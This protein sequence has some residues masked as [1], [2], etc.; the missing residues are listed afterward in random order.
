MR[1]RHLSVLLATLAAGS[2]ALAADAARVTLPVFTTAE[3][4]NQSCEQGLKATRTAI[5]TLARQPLEAV[6]TATTLAMWDD[7]AIR[8]EDFASPV[9]IAQNVSP[10]KAVRDAAEACSQ[11]VAEL[12][13][14]LYQNVE[15]Y[16]R[17]RRVTD[18]TGAAA[19]LRKV[20]IEGFEDAGATLPEDKRK[21]AKEILDRID[22][23]AIEFGR[24]TREKRGTITFTAS[25]LEGLPA[26]YLAKFKP[27][28]KGSVT[29]PMDYPAYFPFMENALSGEAR[30]RYFIAFNSVGGEGNLK[31]LDEASQ[32]R[33]ELAGLFGRASYAEHVI[34]RRM[35]GSPEKVLDF[36]GRVKG[37][38][39]EVEQR[40]LQAL[41]EAKASLLGRT[42]DEVK[43]ER[44]D[45]PFYTERVR[46]AKF[47]IDQNAMRRYFP[48]EPTIAWVINLAERM[49]DV[50]FVAADVPKWHEDV[51]FYDILDAGG[52]R[53]AGAYLDPY[54]RE[55][56]Y[57][58]AAV[59]GLFGA[60]SRVGR[61]PISTLVTNFDRKGLDYK[62]ARTLL[63]EFG[64]LLHGTLSKAQYASLAG[65]NVRRDFVEAPSQMFEEWARN[66]ETLALI[67]Q[68]CK[69]C[70][71]I[72]AKLLDRLDQA[73]R[74][75]AGIH[76]TRQHALAS[77][78]MALVGPTPK[79]AMQAWRDIETGS[80]LGHVEGTLFPAGF[81]HMMGGYSAG[82]YGYMW[83]EVLAL[84]MASQW[85]GKLLDKKTG[86][87]YLDTVLA[88][89][90]EVPPEKLV[91]DFLGREPSNEPFFAEIT[92]Q[93][94]H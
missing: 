1:L 19:Q 69:D 74:F 86:H 22:A 11:K 13:N 82:Y 50:K 29:L 45:L 8:I 90:G 61:T 40:D 33:R 89:G 88:R 38:L 52:K 57:N 78:D 76:Y 71:T 44:W 66:G 10:I 56:K 27:D 3:A 25:E 21:R 84:D 64:H 62:E 54:P 7:L 58:H 16:E 42:V 26:N 47:A 79:P 37:K 63:H 39:A 32:L 46:R 93:R 53:I 6:S 4:V 9:E 73:R 81:G 12:N 55:G 48:T 35:A 87:R 43:I 18:A 60:S 49:Y 24:N 85:K 2:S 5:D 28:D 17:V 77:F 20:A 68:Q 14:S 59:W 92:G 94:K 75:G 67:K 65:T 36:L 91:R 80:A 51:R 15:V 70:P 34:Q 72:D 23:L 30:R 31:I 83:S 41:R